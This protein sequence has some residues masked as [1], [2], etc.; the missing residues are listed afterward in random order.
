MECGRETGGGKE[1]TFER[2]TLKSSPSTVFSRQKSW[3]N[4]KSESKEKSHYCLAMF[5]FAFLTVSLASGLVYGWPS[6]RRNLVSEE[7]S[8]LDEKALGVIFTVGSW[9]TQ[10]GRFFFGLARDRFG[11]SKTACFSLLAVTAGSF[12]LAFSPKNNATALAVSLFLVGLGSGAQLCLQP[13]AGLFA[14]NR[15]GTVL[16]SLSGAFQVSGLVFL[17]LTAISTNRKKSFGYFSGCLVL[18]TIVAA[19]VLPK[20]QFSKGGGTDKSDILIVDGEEKCDEEAKHQSA[21]SGGTDKLDLN[22]IEE[23]EFE[24]NKNDVEGNKLVNIEIGQRESSIVSPTHTKKLSNSDAK[25]DECD[26]SHHDSVESHHNDSTEEETAIKLIW[27]IEYVLLLFWFSVLII[28]LQY[29]I[30]TIGFQLERKGDNSGTYTSLFSIIYASSAGLSP[31]GGKIADIFGLGVAQA[32]GTILTAASLLILASDA[33][34]NVQVVGLVA[35]GVGRMMTFGMFFSN[36]GKRFGYTH[37]GTLAGLGLIT[38]AIVSLA[39]YP[40]ISLAAD[41]NESM[42]N[43]VCGVSIL[44]LTLPYCL[45][46]GLRERKESNKS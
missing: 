22:K 14:K 4:L 40:L 28:P 18:L 9:S 41:G 20:H 1:V 33:N 11:T 31:F 38:T 42:V 36:V 17:V 35:Y 12:G 26:D 25:N 32:N 21:K 34:L 24:E 43:V 23:E 27:T 3:A 8:T 13:V 30:A 45:W 15:Q 2:Q 5:S 44:V 10:G 7:E 6:L 37:F 16:A 19:A 39:Q 46:L 29:Y